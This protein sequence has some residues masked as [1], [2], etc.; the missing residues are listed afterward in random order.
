[1]EFEKCFFY[2][3]RFSGSNRHNKYLPIS[4]EKRGAMILNRALD[5]KVFDAWA[6]KGWTAM[7]SKWQFE[8]KQ[9][10]PSQKLDSV[11][12]IYID[13][14][15]GVPGKLKSKRKRFEKVP[16]T[17]LRWLACDLFCEVLPEAWIYEINPKTMH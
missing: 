6:S 2:R 5:D 4:L 15:T 11:F 14:E 10:L 13:E 16:C 8:P 7:E 17:A 3:F 9:W 1:M 12:I